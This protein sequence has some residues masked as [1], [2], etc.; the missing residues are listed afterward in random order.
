MLSFSPAE[1]AF[2]KDLF[3]QVDA[4]FA[5]RSRHATAAYW[6]KAAFWLKETDD[7]PW[8]LFITSD[9]IGPEQVPEGYTKVMEAAGHVTHPLFDPFRVKV[10]PPGDRF[11][12]AALELY[13]RY[14]MSRAMRPS[15]R[16][17][18]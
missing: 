10:I 7:E 3:A 5:N 9:R 8:Y 15:P 2:K 13:R 18:Q 11:A 14:P 17:R 6:V 4:H 1:S 16:P 12:Q